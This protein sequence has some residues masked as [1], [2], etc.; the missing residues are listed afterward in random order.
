M[1]PDR[2][3]EWRSFSPEIT[4]ALDAAKAVVVVWTQAAVTSDWVY[5]EAV[6]AANRRTIVTVHA[7]DLDL[8]LIPLPFNVF[9]SCRI[10]DMRAV[11]EAIEKRLSGELSPPPS[12]MPGPGFRGFLLDPKRESLPSRAVAT[13]PASLLLAKH[14]LVPF[15]DIHG[16]AT[17][18]VRWAT[19]VPDTPWNG[20]RS[21]AS[22]MR[23]PAS[24]RR[25]R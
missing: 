24:A 25:A 2:A 15:V 1:G 6:R 12:A 14:Q 16:C 4:R 9:H 23:P 11:L 8:N 13:R 19:S 17:N 20:V 10:G 18:F 7:D 3:S 21:A 5:A 22:C